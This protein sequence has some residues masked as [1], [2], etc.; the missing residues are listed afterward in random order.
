MTRIRVTDE[1]N[2]T[3]ARESIGAPLGALFDD[4]VQAPRERTEGVRITGVAPD[5]SADR[6]ELAGR[7]FARI[8][9]EALHRVEIDI[10]PRSAA[11]ALVVQDLRANEA[12]AHPDDVHPSRGE[13]IEIVR[14]AGDQ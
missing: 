1:R 2:R 14:H 7:G 11:G 5:L 13:A 3:D 8:E 12:R 6:L 9:D 10:E 4:R